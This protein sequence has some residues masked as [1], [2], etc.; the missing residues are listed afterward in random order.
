M[1]NVTP[2]HKKDSK[3]ITNNYR[4]ISLL[5]IFAKV[6][7]KIIFRNLYNQLVSNNLI[8][9]NQSG[10]RPGDSVTN[11]LIYLVDEIF[12]SFECNENLEVRSVNLDM[13]KAFDEV[14]HEGIIFK[15]KQNGVT[16]NLLKLLENNISNRKQR[17]V[18]NGMHSDWGLINSDVPPSS[19]FGPLLFLVYTND[20]ENGIKSSMKYLRMIPHYFL[21]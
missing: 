11:Q 4:P 15:L 2:I 18:L 8:T 21:S 10:F 3:Q 9:N 6:F 13:S 1:A 16:G 17:V 7:E 19:V 12:K 5:P 20:L 14:W